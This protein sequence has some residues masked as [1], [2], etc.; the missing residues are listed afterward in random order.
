MEGEPFV[1]V[2]AGTGDNIDAKDHLPNGKKYNCYWAAYGSRFAK[3]F[4]L[5]KALSERP[6]LKS[7]L[8]A[9]FPYEIIINAIPK[10][11]ALA[12]YGEDGTLIDVIQDTSATAPW[13][14]EAEQFG[15]HLYLASWYNSYL[16]RVKMDELH[17]HNKL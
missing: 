13:L 17:I 8:C 3:P 4:T 11:S 15:D 10:L 14:S 5:L 16:A 2:M 6:F 7:I 1:R 12:V 9:L